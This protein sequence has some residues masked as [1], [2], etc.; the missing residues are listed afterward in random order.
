[1]QS[2]Q[3][4]YNLTKLMNKLIDKNLFHCGLNLL[5]GGSGLYLVRVRARAGWGILCEGNWMWSQST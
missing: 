3:S 4:E 1:M 5:Q 2:S